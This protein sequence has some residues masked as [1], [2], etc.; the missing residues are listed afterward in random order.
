MEQLCLLRAGKGQGVGE[1]PSPSGLPQ[2]FTTMCSLAHDSRA[3]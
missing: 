1:P 2:L 3:G